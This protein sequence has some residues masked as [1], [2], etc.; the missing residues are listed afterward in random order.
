MQLQIGTHST[1]CVVRMASMLTVLNRDGVVASGTCF[2]TCSADTS[3]ANETW[4]LPYN[5]HS[6]YYA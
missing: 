5:L 2:T 6:V 1:V 4:P 3:Q